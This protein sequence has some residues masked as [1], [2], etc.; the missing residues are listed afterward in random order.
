MKP[1]DD[2]E[3]Y[4]LAQIAENKID[5]WQLPYYPKAMRPLFYI[6]ALLAIFTPWHVGFGCAWL[7]VW[8]WKGVLGFQQKMRDE[9]EFSKLRDRH[10]ATTGSDEY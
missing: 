9:K 10:I 2:Y 8:A 6:F 1:L 3:Q 5:Y 7:G 4:R